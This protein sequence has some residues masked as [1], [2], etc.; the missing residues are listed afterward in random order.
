ME[1][2]KFKNLKNNGN[3]TKLSV[4]GDGRT[5][6][7][8]SKVKES[9]LFMKIYCLS[10]VIVS[11]FLSDHDNNKLDLPFEVIDEEQEIILFPKSTFVLGHS[12]TGRTTILTMKLFQKQYFH[13][14]AV[15]AAYGIKST[16]IPL[17]DQD[18]E[19]SI[20]NDKAIIC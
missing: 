3:D 5:Y 4:Y 13:H 17:L 14:M 6:V 9:I 7:D 19:S 2:I 12:G 8:N 20:V 18:K 10:S 16:D 15:E 11:H 1:I